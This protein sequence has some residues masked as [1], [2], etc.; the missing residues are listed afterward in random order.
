MSLRWNDRI[1]RYE[2]DFYVGGRKGERVQRRLKAGFTSQEAETIYKRHLKLY[3]IK[4]DDADLGLTVSKL[5]KK[6]LEWYEMHRQPSTV[7]DARRVFET[8]VETIL[9]GIAAETIGEDDVQTYQTKRRAAGAG[10]RTIN[11]EL[12]YFYGCLRWAAGRG[13]ISPRAWTVSALPYSRP[14]PQVLT[15]KE[16][17]QVLDAAQPIVRAYLLLLYG[18][19]LRHTEARMIREADIDRAENAVIVKQKGGSFKRLP[20][21]A[22]V[23]ASIDEI[24]VPGAPENAEGYIF[25]NPSTEKPMR[26]FRKGIQRACAKAGITK[27]VYPHLFRHSFA[28]HLMGSGANLRIIQKMMGHAQIQST[29]WYTHVDQEQMKGASGMIENAMLSARN[30]ISKA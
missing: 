17:V 20:L 25:F 19:G 10:N 1:N 13:L 9:G 5:T 3:R 29:E 4:T 23:L 21:P 14:L 22:S 12:A 7:E 8:H 16:V 30:H 28:T 18:V 27:R 6:Y 15:V 24:D 11:K 26:Y 2:I